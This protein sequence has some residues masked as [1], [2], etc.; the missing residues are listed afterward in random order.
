MDKFPKWVRLPVGV[1]DI[2]SPRA[3]IVLSLLI[4][5]R[6]YETGDSRITARELANI[7]R[8][9]RVTVARAV[10]ELKD[11]GYITEVFYDPFAEE[12]IYHS[13]EVIED[14]QSNIYRK[15]VKK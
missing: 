3:A 2:L 11:K 8:C 6:D 5:Q 9:S 15:G 10:Q 4:D 1:L 12:Y 7:M 14:K 13:V